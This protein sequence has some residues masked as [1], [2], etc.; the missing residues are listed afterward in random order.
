MK[1]PA[2]PSLLLAQPRLSFPP[3]FLSLTCSTKPALTEVS[4]GRRT[5]CLMQDPGS[6]PLG[7]PAGGGFSVTAGRDGEAAGGGVPGSGGGGG[8][9]SGARGRPG[10]HW[11]GGGPGSARPHK[12]GPSVC[13]PAR[14]CPAMLPPALPWLL[15]ACCLCALPRGSGTSGPRH[16]EEGRGGE[17][18]EGRDTSDPPPNLGEGRLPSRGAVGAGLRGT[19]AQLC[20]SSPPPR[21]PAGFPQPFWRYRNGADLPKSQVCPSLPSP[22]ARLEA[23]RCGGVGQSRSSPGWPEGGGKRD[24]PK[25]GSCGRKLVS[26]WKYIVKSPGWVAKRVGR[27]NPFA[28]RG[29][30]WGR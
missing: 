3:S 8:S 23:T 5:G 16:G 21:V 14:R 29:G 20:V 10:A 7:P 12:G 25:A 2:A 9:W 1:I 19:S 18:G 26:D 30:R 24:S 11:L 13:P 27:L 28:A 6:L 22:P 15:A 4:E 17:G